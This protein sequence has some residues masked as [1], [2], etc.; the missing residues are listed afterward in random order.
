M[1]LFQRKPELDIPSNLHI[2]NETG[3]LRSVSLAGIFL[4]STSGI[5]CTYLRNSLHS[6]SLKNKNIIAL[7]VYC[8]SVARLTRKRVRVECALQKKSKT[9]NIAGL[10]GP[11]FTILTRWP[12]HQY[13]TAII[14]GMQLLPNAIVYN[15]QVLLTFLNLFFI[16]FLYETLYST[17]ERLTGATV[18]ISLE[19]LC[20]FSLCPFS[21][22]S[23]RQSYPQIHRRPSF[24]D[25]P[26]LPYSRFY[27]PSFHHPLA[28]LRL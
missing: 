24:L 7:T 6:F 3:F 10:I 19:N 1:S 17:R 26:P 16:L 23:N 12:C 18:T 25:C 8:L 28:R 20:P 27:F 9:D 4:R 2:Y 11:L 14:D 21:C 13:D 22:L 15:T 5:T